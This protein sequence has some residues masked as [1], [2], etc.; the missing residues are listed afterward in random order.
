MK[1]SLNDDLQS[2]YNKTKSD[3]GK[4]MTTPET[5]LKPEQLPEIREFL[6][7]KFKQMAPSYM[8]KKQNQYKEVQRIKA[9][10]SNP[11]QKRQRRS[12]SQKNDPKINKLMNTLKALLK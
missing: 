9:C 7:S 12:R 3:I 1:L 10:R 4:E 6:S 11:G 8:D 5:L 2:N